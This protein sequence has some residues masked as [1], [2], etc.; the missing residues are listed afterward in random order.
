MKLKCTGDAPFKLVALAVDE[1]VEDVDAT[2]DVE[3]TEDVEAALAVE[4]V[5]AAL[6]DELVVDEPKVDELE[7]VLVA[8]PIE[9]SPLSA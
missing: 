1:V 9:K 4:E 6:A 5:E 3:A 2:D 7:L 8:A